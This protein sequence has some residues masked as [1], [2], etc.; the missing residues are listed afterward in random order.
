MGVTLKSFFANTF[1][2]KK[3]NSKYKLFGRRGSMYYE[4]DPSRISLDYAAKTALSG[5]VSSIGA[6]NNSK[7]IKRVQK[8]QQEKRDDELK[9]KKEQEKAAKKTSRQTQ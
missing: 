5:V 8:E 3:N 1:V 9:L 2:V 6:R 4:R 7:E